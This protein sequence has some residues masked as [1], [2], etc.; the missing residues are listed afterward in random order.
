VNGGHDL[1]GMQGLGPIAPEPDEPVFHSEWERRVF[2]LTL[3]L[4]TQG[5][6]NIDRSRHARENRHPAEYLRSS[7]YE[8]WLKG[9]ERLA[10]EEG[11][12]APGEIDAGRAVAPPPPHARP[13]LAAAQVEPLLRR[14]GP[15]ERPVAAPPRFAPGDRVHVRD[16]I[17]GGHTRAPRYCRGR[18]GVVHARHG[19]HVFPDANAHGGGERPCHLYA[20]RFAARDLWGEA[21][22]AKDAVFVDLWEP[23]LE[24]AS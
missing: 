5:R 10:Q 1:G 4:G 2:A 11:F 13:P 9:L 6:W 8:L 19:G 14:G 16:T 21:A 3:A 15:S 22:G 17:T 12:L 24:A 7:Y 20:V 23:Y 18:A